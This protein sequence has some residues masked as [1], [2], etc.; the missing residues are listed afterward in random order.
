[1]AKA[2]SSNEVGHVFEPKLP[3]EYKEDHWVCES[4]ELKNSRESLSYGSAAA[5]SVRRPTKIDDALDGQGD[6]KGEGP[7]INHDENSNL[8]PFDGFAYVLVSP[9]AN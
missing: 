4:N 3:R 7:S 2:L 1:M 9:I 8:F 6:Q 5:S